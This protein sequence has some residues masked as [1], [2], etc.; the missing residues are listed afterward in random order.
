MLENY[1]PG[2][3][4]NAS[5]KLSNSASSKRNQEPELSANG[6]HFV[7]NLPVLMS[8]FECQIAC[9]ISRQTRSDSI[10]LNGLICPPKKPGAEISPPRAI[11]PTLWKSKGFP[12][13]PSP[14]TGLLSTPIPGISI[15]TTSPGCNCSTEPGAPV[16]IMSPGRR[17]TNWLMPLTV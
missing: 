11:G 10:F 6:P 14:T 8:Y 17:V 7:S 2:T 1:G 9:Q 12:Y 13:T 5:N 3:D 15:S 16:R 4:R